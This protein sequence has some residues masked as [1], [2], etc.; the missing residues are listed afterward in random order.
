MDISTLALLSAALIAFALVSG[1]L[2]KSILTPP[3]VFTALGLLISEY[4]L[5]WI[6]IDVSQPV[7]HLVAELTLVLVLFTD[8]SRINLSL[9]RREHDLPIRLLAVGMPLT[10]LAG[11][12]AALW[13]LPELGLWPAALLA[14]ILMPTDA[15]LGQAVVSDER[16]PARIRQ[17]L[18]VES[19]LNDGIALPVVLL[20]L[21]MC[22]AAAGSEGRD[23]AEWI[24]F[25]LLQVVL[26]PLVGVAVG[27]LGGRLVDLATRRGLMSHSFQALSALALSVLAFA[28]AELVHG[29]GFIAAFCAGLTLGNITRHLCS[30]LYEFGEAE[31]QL[32]TLLVFLG[33]GATLL[34]EAWPHLDARA[35]IYAVLS[36]TLIRLV[37]AALALAGK[38]LRGETVLFLGWFG[39]RGIASI[40]FALVVLEEIEG[41]FA[42]HQKVVAV[43][44][45]TVAL[46]IVAHGMTA[47]PAA[48]WY[49]R[50]MEG[51]TEEEACEH[52][53]VAEMPLRM[54]PGRSE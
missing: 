25:A 26:G 23:T 16:V 38:G 1:R 40:L 33:F 12:L 29:N 31:G 32:L 43:V 46:S 10:L 15:A 13:L 42:A 36:L 53:A 24:N 51:R 22:G 44:M 34:P 18:N 17:T 50:R 52:R 5:G 30:R 27:A 20:L 8:A 35:W 37:P 28:S 19:G 48:G 41:G 45:A 4:G 2:E 14:A 6:E 9:L 21:S 11:T 39:P 3:L 54:R 7:A 49:A 47:Y